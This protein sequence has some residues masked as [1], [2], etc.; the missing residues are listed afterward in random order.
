MTGNDSLNGGGETDRLSGGRG[1]D[2]SINSPSGR[3]S[4]RR[5]RPRR[6]QRRD[7]RPARAGELRHGRDRVR[8]NNREKRRT[9]GCE[10]RY[11]LRDRQSETPVG[12][13]GP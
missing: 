5:L 10:V 4:D 12:S 9:R 7:C 2:S 13:G 8:L 6:D 11:V 1:N 3:T